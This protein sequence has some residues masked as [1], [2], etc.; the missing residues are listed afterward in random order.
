MINTIYFVRKNYGFGYIFIFQKKNT[1][2]SNLME[3][4]F[5]YQ[6]KK[7]F[8]GNLSTICSEDIL[9]NEFSKFGTVLQVQIRRCQRSGT[10]MGYGFVKMKSSSDA[11]KAITTLDG[12]LL[13]GRKIR[14]KDAG[15]GLKSETQFNNSYSLYIKFES[16]ESGKK[17]DEVKL[18]EIFSHYGEII[19]VTIRRIDKNV[20]LYLITTFH[21]IIINN[22]III[23]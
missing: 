17:T 19:D 6:E 9:F 8:L 21:I 23:I 16:I 10:S 20:I 1:K 22:R 13:C 12:I 7:L 5:V 3:N 14:I 4:S 18:R 15:I 2:I 11:D